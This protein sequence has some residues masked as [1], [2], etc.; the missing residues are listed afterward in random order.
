MVCKVVVLLYTR[1]CQ[2][3]YYFRCGFI[4]IELSNTCRIVAVL[5]VGCIHHDNYRPTV[6]WAFIDL[7][8]VA[9]MLMLNVIILFLFPH[10]R[11]AWRSSAPRWLSRPLAYWARFCL[12]AS[13]AFP[14]QEAGASRHLRRHH[15]HRGLLDIYEL[16]R[17]N[18]TYP[19]FLQFLPS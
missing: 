19:L 1:P 10:F 8:F 13:V 17:G 16:V 7:S 14:L 4:D 6:K 2:V 9:E 3:M 12:S 11:L 15:C 5:P 18:L